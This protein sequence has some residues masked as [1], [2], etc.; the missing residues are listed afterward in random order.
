MK[1]DDRN[2]ASMLQKYMDGMTTV[3]EETRLASYIRKHAEAPDGIDG[4]D[5]L[6]YREMFAMFEPKKAVVKVLIRRWGT[7]AAVV[8]LMA[9]MTWWFGA[10][11][12][13]LGNDGGHAYVAMTACADSI[14][15][16]AVVSDTAKAEIMPV[17]I[18]AVRRTV[19]K[20][21]R[22]RSTPP[23]PRNYMAAAD[24]QQADSVGNVNLEEAVRQ[25]DVLMQAVYM[26]QQSDI[27]SMMLKY[28]V[29]VAEF[30]DE[31]AE[32]Y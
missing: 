10:D 2:I 5:W 6:A 28:A 18:P 21:K 3:D 31:Y 20:V 17:K 11:G 32:E 8:M 25:A 7:V 27:N 24:C 4:D 14:G 26:Q 23:T 29:A 19:K 22:M 9:V 15:N 13:H 1:I 16:E 30:E 12:R